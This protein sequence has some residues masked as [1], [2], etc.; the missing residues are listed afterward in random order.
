[1]RLLEAVS[2][3][4]GS[5]YDIHVAYLAACEILEDET[6]Y[7]N[8]IALD[9]KS[10]I[11]HYQHKRRASGDCT[12]TRS[13]VLLIDAGCKVNGYGSDITRTSVRAHTQS[14]FKNLVKA[15]ESLELALLNGVRPGIPYPELHASALRGI[16]EILSQHQ[17]V[18]AS[19]DEISESGIPS[20]FMPHGV[21][22]L[23]GLQVH[24]VG[25]HQRNIA[26]DRL[27]PPSD[28]PALRNTR[29][30]AE[31]MVFTVEPGLYFIASLL[32][33]ERN[34]SRGK[35]FNWPLIDELIPCGGIRIE[36]NVL[37]TADGF[38][39]LTRGS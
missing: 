8:I 3:R 28:S 32:N 39:N 13:Q 16:A 37:V 18:K 15:M 22:H 7:T 1:M 30:M 33:K 29:L 14:T 6:P 31:R 26:G 25:G 20:V 19:A 24:D 2:K 36:D 5:E 9:E 4:G 10:A 21:G 35:A 23:L 11:L 38:V 17:I 12:G 27:A 34:S